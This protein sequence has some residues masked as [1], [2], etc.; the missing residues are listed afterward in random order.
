MKALNIPM[1]N[2]D[3]E[4]LDLLKQPTGLG[5]R[6]FVLLMADHY[7]SCPERLK[8]ETGQARK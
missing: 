2:S 3:F 6:R 7:A 1:D 4:R 8:E 5:W